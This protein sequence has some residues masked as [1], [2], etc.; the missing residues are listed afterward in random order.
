MERDQYFIC[1]PV[2]ENFPD[3]L[4]GE[5]LV[6]Q[7]REEGIPVIYLAPQYLFIVGLGIVNVQSVTVASEKLATLPEKA[8]LIKDGINYFQTSPFLPFPSLL[9][10]KAPE[11]NP[12]AGKLDSR[13]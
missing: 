1:L 12:G 10:D 2:S 4:P 7:D 9:C 3:I 6:L 11:G 8:V 13:L 5:I